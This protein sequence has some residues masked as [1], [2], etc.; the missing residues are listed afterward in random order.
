MSRGRSPPARAP[1]A[2]T[3]PRAREAPPGRPPPP[4]GP[5][6]LRQPSGQQ[7]VRGQILER[8]EA[9]TE[10]SHVY[11][12]ETRGWLAQRE[13]AGGPRSRPGEV[14]REEPFGGPRAEPALGCDP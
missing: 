13:I 3:P 14:P 2:R 7:I 8:M 10:L 6:R 11:T 1:R 5:S 12:V 4:S 9:R